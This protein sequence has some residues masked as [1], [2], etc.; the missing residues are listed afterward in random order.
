M[1]SDRKEDNRRTRTRKNS[2]RKMCSE[3]CLGSNKRSA[4]PRIVNMYCLLLFLSVRAISKRKIIINGVLNKFIVW[5]FLQTRR[6]SLVSINTVTVAVML[7][8][9][10]GVTR[11]LSPL[12]GTQQQRRHVNINFYELVLQACYTR[13]SAAG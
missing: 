9:N 12:S 10:K 7:K 2:R 4:L 8:I 1:R 5:K 13:V 3:M 11:L 6:F